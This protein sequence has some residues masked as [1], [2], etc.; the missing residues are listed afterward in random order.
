MKRSIIF[1]VVTLGAF[2]ILV[3]TDVSPGYGLPLI[4][5]LVWALL[6]LI[7][8]IARIWIHRKYSGKNELGGGGSDPGVD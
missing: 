2:F 5:L 3:L 7:Y 1:G 6:L 8:V 4:I